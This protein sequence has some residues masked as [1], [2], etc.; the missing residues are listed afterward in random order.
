MLSPY[1]SAYT[2][3]FIYRDRLYRFEAENYGDYY[4]VEAVVC[5]LNTA[6]EHNGQRERYIGLYTGDQ[7]ACFVFADPKVFVP[8]AQK[9]GLPLSEHPSEAMRAGRAYEQRVFDRPEA[10]E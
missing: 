3:Q 7:C 10:E 1:D 8:V 5:A 2:V 6:L 9:Y 4:D